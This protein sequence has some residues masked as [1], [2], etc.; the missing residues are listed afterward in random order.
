[1]KHGARPERVDVVLN[2]IDHTRFRRLHD[3]RAAVR[4]TLGFSDADFVIGTVGRVERQKRFDILLD[5][6][7]PIARQNSTVRV[8]IAGDGSL[9]RAIET[10]AAGLG[11]TSTCSFLGHRT[12]VAQLHSAFDLFVQSSD[13]EGTPNSV[14]EAMACE[15]PIV[16]TA[17]GGTAELARHGQEALIVAPGD[18]NGLRAAIADCLQRGA[19]V[20]ARVRAARQRI[21][22]EL[23][24]E[25]RM[26]R[27]E[28][29]YSE[30][31]GARDEQDV[32]RRPQEFVG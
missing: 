22:T 14:L 13:Y 7:A 30:I 23:S 12:D 21:L 17:A 1:V 10:H 6:I 8:V 16:A 19:D 25:V 4:A 29:I 9:R 15:T 5:A 2:G 18:T 3:R 28:R 24:F 26:A 32:A 11:L 20:Q 27:V 31:A